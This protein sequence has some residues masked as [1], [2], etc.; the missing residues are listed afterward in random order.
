MNILFVN[1][2]LIFIIRKTE[3]ERDWYCY[4][5]RYLQYSKFKRGRYQARINNSIQFEY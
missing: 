4:I 5:H 2:Y 3:R 1:V